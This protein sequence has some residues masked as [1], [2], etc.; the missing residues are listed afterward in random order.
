MKTQKFPDNWNCILA[1][2]CI[3][4]ELCYET[5]EKRYFP[6]WRD[7]VFK[8]S[9]VRGIHVEELVYVALDFDFI[10][11]P[12]YNRLVYNPTGDKLQDYEIHMVSQF[13]NALQCYNGLLLGSYR[14]QD[15]PQPHAVAWSHET[16]MIYAPERRIASIDEFDIDCFYGIINRE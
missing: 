16:S 4:T 13:Q 15:R 8:D 9:Q 11:V 7:V 12:F 14:F 3:V 5:L 10:M 2:F 1:S 6:N